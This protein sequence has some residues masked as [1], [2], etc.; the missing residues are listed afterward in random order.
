MFKFSRIIIK[1][2]KNYQFL[3]NKDKKRVVRNAPPLK[4]I[5]LLTY[6]FLL[7]TCDV[8]GMRDQPDRNRGGEVLLV[9][10]LE[11]YLSPSKLH[12]DNQH[13]N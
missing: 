4:S 6:Y 11:P 10:E 12:P 9:L 2:K 1:N 8:S 5:D 3:I 7:I 13:K